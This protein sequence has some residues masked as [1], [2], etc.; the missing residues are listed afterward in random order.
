[1][2]Y[3]FF[4][5]V[6]VSALA[7]AS[8]YGGIARAGDLPIEW[9][10]PAIYNWSGFYAGF[11][12]GAIWGSYNPQTATNHGSAFS[13]YS[14]GVI[15]AS[16]NQTINPL[17]FAG[18]AQA[19]Y[20]WQLG[21]W[22]AGIEGDLSYLRLNGAASTDVQLAPASTSTA[23]ISAYGNTNWMATL[24]PRVGWVANNWLVYATGGVAVTGFSDDFALTGVRAAGTFFYQQSSH[25]E[26]YPVGYA[27]GAGIETAITGRWSLKAEY[28]HV[29][30][31]R[32]TAT[33]TTANT[34][35]QVTTQSADLSTDL[36]RVGLNY[37]WGDADPA[38][39]FGGAGP[40][41]AFKAPQLVS[42]VWNKSDWQFDAGVRTWWS[43]GTIGA[44][45]PVFTN[46][47]GL[48]SRLIWGNLDSLSGETYGRVDHVSGW[49]VKGF[50]G[51]GG[52]Y[53]GK[54][55]DEDFPAPSFPGTAYSNTLSSSTGSI[56]YA[57]IDL[58]Y[59]FWKSPGAK[60]GPFVGY[61]Y[62]TQHVNSFGCAQIAAGAAC[63]GTLPNY[64]IISEDD[65]FN[66]LR[67][68][69]SA[70]YM[71]TDKLKFVGDAA[72]LPLVGFSGVDEHN[73]RALVLTEAAS[74]GDGVMIEALLSY[75]VA[76]SWNVGVG[77]RYWAWN[78]P[79]G[80]DSFQFN[81]NGSGPPTTQPAR[82]AAERY[83][84]FLQSDYHW[85]DTMAAAS[86]GSASA[87]R[88]PSIVA[89][90]MNWTGFYAG[91]HLGGGWSDANWSDPF[92]TT[93]SRSGA[94]NIPG[95]GDA[96]HATGPLGGGQI[97]A[98]WQLGRWVLGAEVDASAADLRGANTC[99]SG[100]GGVNC[101]HI[102]DN[103][104]TVTG[105]LGFAW[106]RALLYA[107]GGAAWAETAYNLDG[108]TN[109]SLKLGT[110]STNV[111]ASGWV[112][113]GGVEYALT[114]H[115]TTSFEY[116]HIGLDSVTVAFPTVRVINANTIVIRQ[117]IDVIKLGL[118]YKID[119]PGLIVSKN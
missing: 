8:G 116:D 67:V 45:Q 77:G 73:G 23:V 40:P 84:V 104:E 66:S 48:A 9:P 90:A 44:P 26:N 61:S 91:G 97:G 78:V 12:A 43:D 103:L 22:V 3:S 6:A 95:F 80:H 20:N 110:G 50:L 94:P 105:R 27:V 1:M 38:S 49:F 114:N 107:K 108:N 102:V 98:N 41:M 24:R 42:T 117:S 71:L 99:F 7:V 18:G 72:Y 96:T 14:S 33:K 85:G 55:N 15:D 109:G 89:S 81:T 93:I 101:E 34:A 100:L 52:I 37:R 30:F 13:D 76:A 119:W 17:G 92:G 118:N 68:G 16:G 51:A 65:S 53:N 21:R 5:G 25:I 19:G 4:G 82:Y 46:S 56:G 113:A 111:T 32:F 36:V 29:D 115:W 35:V 2:K 88:T 31:G 83:G 28:L 106:N 54:L 58:G 69:V 87:A 11:N 112:A 64:L 47:Q 63:A 74:G 57:T 86:G 39:A 70:E 79:N 62:Y 59:S 60:L 75:E 10:P